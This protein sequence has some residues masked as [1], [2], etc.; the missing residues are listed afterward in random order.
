MASVTVGQ[1][2]VRPHEITQILEGQAGALTHA[3]PND[4]T[5]K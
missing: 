4:N 1:L 3:A 5:A 2:V